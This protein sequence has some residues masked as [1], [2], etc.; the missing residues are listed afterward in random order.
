MYTKYLRETL[1]LEVVEDKDGRGF[2]SYGFD[3]IP[4]VD[5]P[6]C[7]IQDIWVD[8]LHREKSVA[9]GMADSVT[10]IAKRHG[11]KVLF[12]SVCGTSKNPDRSLKVL[13]AY[14]M[15]LYSVGDNVIYLAKEIE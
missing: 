10:D 12:G 6:H 14:G 9:A 13:Q 2:A 15:K 11:K 5:F 3:C 7:Y 4:G 8:P 1:G